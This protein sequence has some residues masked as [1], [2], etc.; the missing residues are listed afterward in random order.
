LAC[1]HGIGGGTRQYRQL[2]GRAGQGGTRRAARVSIVAF[3]QP[4]PKSLELLTRGS[5]G[6][7][8]CCAGEGSR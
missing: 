4:T 1:A 7:L 2:V 5:P 6:A 8:H 3:E